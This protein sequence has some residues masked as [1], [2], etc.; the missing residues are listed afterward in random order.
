MKSA[1]P[2]DDRF[3]LYNLSVALGMVGE[4]AH[5]LTNE[6]LFGGMMDMGGGYGNNLGGDGANSIEEALS[7][8]IRSQSSSSDEMDNKVKMAGNANEID[9]ILV[10]NSGGEGSAGVP[11]QAAADDAMMAESLG[12]P[13]APPPYG[14]ESSNG[15]PAALINTLMNNQANDNDVSALLAPDDDGVPF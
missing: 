15:V 11:S 4:F 5:N 14:Q 9:N 8:S 10:D 7:H 3:K 1:L 12:I 2:V 13:K 6:N